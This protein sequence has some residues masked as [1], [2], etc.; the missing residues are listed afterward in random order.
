MCNCITTKQGTGYRMVNTNTFYN[1]TSDVGGV[2]NI[3]M[4][5]MFERS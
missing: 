3:F 1:F 5:K 4:L 2:G